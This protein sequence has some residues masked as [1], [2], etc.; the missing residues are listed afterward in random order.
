MWSSYFSI[1][2]IIE[3]DYCTRNFVCLAFFEFD[4]A[5]MRDSCGMYAEYPDEYLWDRL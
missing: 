4:G 1:G 5:E 3:R 2:G